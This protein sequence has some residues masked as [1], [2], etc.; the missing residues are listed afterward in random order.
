MGTPLTRILL[1]IFATGF[2]RMHAGMIAATFLGVA[3]YFFF[4]NVLNQTH[5]PPDQIILYRLIFVLTLLNSPLIAVLVAIAWLFYIIK[6]WNYI[7]AQLTLPQHQF[8]Q[9]SATAI[10]LKKQRY[11]WGIVQGVIMMPILFFS[12]FALITG[13]I[14][15]QNIYIPILLLAYTAILITAGAYRHTY[16]LNHLA[17][18]N[19]PFGLFRLIRHW[20]KPYFSLFLYQLFYKE[21]TTLAITKLLSGALIA[22][23]TF[24][25]ADESPD[26]RTACIIILSIAVTHSVL[27]YQACRFENTRLAFARGFPHTKAHRLANLLAEYSILTIPESLWI[28]IHYKTAAPMLL[29]LNISTAMAFRCMPYH[30]GPDMQKFL[31]RIFLVF[32]TSFIVILFKAS[33]VLVILTAALSLTIFFKYYDHQDRY[34]HVAA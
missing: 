13:I 22:A 21:K 29:L 1:K 15:F 23:G 5:I 8:L 9:Y 14:F 30:T 2:Y 27:L 11:S 31:L 19:Q 20:K 34:I 33:W 28:I 7:A 18:T 24:L 3:V 32:I 4:I 26:I 16:R 25:L 12:L 6:S 10:S 17:A